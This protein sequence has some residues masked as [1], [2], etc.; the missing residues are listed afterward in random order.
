MICTQCHKEAKQL[1]G[2]YWRKDNKLGNIMIIDEHEKL[3]L[4]CAYKR[5]GFLTL[6]VQTM[7]NPTSLA[8]GSP[9]RKGF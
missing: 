7:E 8:Y 4:K 1:Y 3:C 2:P 9:R 6:V 5:E